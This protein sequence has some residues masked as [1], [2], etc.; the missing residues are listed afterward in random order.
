LFVVLS[1][2]YLLVLGNHSNDSPGSF[3]SFSVSLYSLDAAGAVG[4]F[5]AQLMD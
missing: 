3:F 4:Q 5:V 2:S 1:V